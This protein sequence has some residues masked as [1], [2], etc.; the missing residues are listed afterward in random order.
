VAAPA[1][2]GLRRAAVLGALPRLLGAWR[3]AR[4][5]RPRRVERQRA[6]R[7]LRAGQPA[8]RG[9]ADRPDQPVPVPGHDQ[10]PPVPALPAHRGRSGVR[11]ARRGRP[12]PGRGARRAAARGQPDGGP[13]RP[14]RGL[15]GQTRGAGDHPRGGAQLRTPGGARRVPGPRRRRGERLGDLVR[16][17][18]G[19]RPGL[20]DLAG[21]ARR[22]AFT[23][24][25][26]AA[27]GAG[28]PGSRPPPRSARPGR[29]A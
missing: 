13:D 17:R 12:G 3:P 23:R 22:S 21:R 11:Q 25:R 4:P 9:R 16:D 5:G 1:V 24:G 10:A 15:G 26:G 8:A 20:A 29:L 27:P 2:V 14:G 19:A 6:G 18:G 28:R 7:G